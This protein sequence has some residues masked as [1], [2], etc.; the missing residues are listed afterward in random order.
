MTRLGR[1]F[2]TT[3]MTFDPM[4][5]APASVRTP[6][7]MTVLLAHDIRSRACD[8]LGDRVLARLGAS[9]GGC[10]L[11]EV[12]SLES[13]WVALDRARILHE[14][15]LVLACLDLP[16]APRA[17]ATVAEWARSLGL[18]AITV[19]HGRRWLPA[20]SSGFEL[21]VLSPSATAEEI[22]RVLVAMV[23]RT[24]GGRLAPNADAFEPPPE[25]FPGRP[26]WLG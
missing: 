1:W 16:P 10:V 24:A 20:G 26:S 14:E 17:G 3:R 7:A 5:K 4:A 23:R 21:P 15:T 13:A 12:G 11:E 18:P 9:K 2:P 25:S 19:A 8:M 6:R 22:E